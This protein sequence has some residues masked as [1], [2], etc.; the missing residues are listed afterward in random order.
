[1]I[2]LQA[3][4]SGQILP[5]AESML[6]AVLAVEDPQSL[7]VPKMDKALEEID[8]LLGAPYGAA[9][10]DVEE[11]NLDKALDRLKMATVQQ[12]LH[13]PARLLQIQLLCLQRR[14]NIAL[15]RIN[16][17]LEAFSYRE[18]LVPASIYQAFLDKVL[19]TPVWSGTAAPLRLRFGSDGYHVQSIWCSPS[20]VAV[21]WF[22]HLKGVSHDDIAISVYGWDGKEILQTCPDERHSLKMLTLRY[23]VY[24]DKEGKLLV[25]DPRNGKELPESPLAEETFRA[26]FLPADRALASTQLYPFTHFGPSQLATGKAAFSDVALRLGAYSE[27]RDETDLMDVGDFMMP[28]STSCVHE[29]GTVECSPRLGDTPKHIPPQVVPKTVKI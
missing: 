9:L 24:Q 7:L 8:R 29:G 10:Q 23:A 6:N 25:I 19:H 17:L 3:L 18:D 20:V 26:I 4:L 2:P 15:L 5:I 1:M 27:W 13:L 16:D 22:E 21:E 11:G 14:F 12:P 28:Y